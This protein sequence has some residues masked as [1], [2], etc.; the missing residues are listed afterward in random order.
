MDEEEDAMDEE[1]MARCAMGALVAGAEAW[2]DGRRAT[3]TVGA[4]H[5][6]PWVSWCHGAAGGDAG[7]HFTVEY[8]AG[9]PCD[10][11]PGPEQLVGYG[12]TWDATAAFREWRAN[13]ADGVRCA[14]AEGAHSSSG[15][16][17]GEALRAWLSALDDAETALVQEGEREAVQRGLLRC[18]VAQ[19]LCV[20]LP[21]TV[22]ECTRVVCRWH[23]G[24]AEISQYINERVSASIFST[25]GAM[26]LRP[27]VDP[28]AMTE[29]RLRLPCGA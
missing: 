29:R 8:V 6:L 25:E 5:A 13:L 10:R 4:L 17:L 21:P 2:L 24:A 9:A 1:E 20:R 23:G 11:V 19:W 3:P 16:A 28:F 7:Q 18:R 27:Q 22:A 14:E 26:F 15:P 12:V